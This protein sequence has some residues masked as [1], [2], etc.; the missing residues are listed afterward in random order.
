MSFTL[1]WNLPVYLKNVKHEIVEPGNNLSLKS[2]LS[3]VSEVAQ[4]CPTLCNP[5][6][7]SLPGSS[8]HGIFQAKVLEW[9]A[10]PSPGDLPNPGLKPGSP[11]L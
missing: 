7:S 1:E 5:M 11:A 8:V 6:D 10:F 9:V 4:S 2:D 3:L